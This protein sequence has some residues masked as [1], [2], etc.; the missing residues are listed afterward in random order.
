MLE[1]IERK[2]TLCMEIRSRQHPQLQKLLERPP[3]PPDRSEDRH[4]DQNQCK[5]DNLSAHQSWAKNNGAK[6]VRPPPY[7]T[8]T[9]VFWDTA[10]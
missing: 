6:K 4:Q 3:P 10:I 8:Q 5:Q 1:Q 7:P 9:T 2:R